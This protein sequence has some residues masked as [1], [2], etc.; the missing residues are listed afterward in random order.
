MYPSGSWRGYWEQAGFGRQAMHDLVLQFAGGQI[1]GAGRDC[2]GQF[3]FSGNYDDRG[4]VTLV[5][6]YLGRHRV[7]YQGNYD[8]EGT[9]FGRWSIYD[10]S[11]GPF[12]LSPVD[13]EVPADTAIVTIGAAPPEA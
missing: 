13:F 5:K 9:I 4:A 2:V 10:V 8:G 11:W 12:A 6:Q 3:T 7:H 1:M